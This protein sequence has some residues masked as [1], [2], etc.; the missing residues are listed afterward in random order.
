MTQLFRSI[1]YETSVNSKWML[2]E[3]LPRWYD[4]RYTGRSTDADVDKIISVPTNDI[5]HTWTLLDSRQV[6]HAGRVYSGMWDTPIEIV[7]KSDL[8]ESFHNHFIKS[9]PWNETTVFKERL[10]SIKNGD[11]RFG[12]S[13]ENELQ[14]LFAQYD[15]VYENIKENGYKSQK[16]LLNERP[17]LTNEANNDALKTEWNEI[18]VCIARDGTMIRHGSGRHRLVIA[19]ILNVETVPVH[20]RIRHTK[21]QQIRDIFRSSNNVPPRLHKYKNHPDLKDVI[22]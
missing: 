18:S 14:E 6:K 4:Y 1:W 22:N 10:S 11:K 2:Q 20:I 9:I 3:M 12:V 16:E 21:W 17:Q 13:N 19:H 5:I 8:Y 15:C 7:Y